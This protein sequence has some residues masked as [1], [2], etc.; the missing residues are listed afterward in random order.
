MAAPTMR[1]HR[2][3]LEP[4]TNARSALDLRSA[5]QTYQPNL[6]ENSRAACASG[7]ICSFERRDP[8]TDETKINEKAWRYG[9]KAKSWYGWG[10]P[11]GLGLL[12]IAIGVSVALLHVA[13]V[14]R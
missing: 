13:G 12:I 3:G 7:K 4:K 2:R 9:Q 14:I 5:N 10:S 11:V 6:R 1:E 8:M